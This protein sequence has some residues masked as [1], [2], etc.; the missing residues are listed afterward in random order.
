[1]PLSQGA[2]HHI[3]DLACTAMRTVAQALERRSVQIQPSHQ[4][5]QPAIR[6]TWVSP[7]D[8]RNALDMKALQQELL[9]ME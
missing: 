6:A 2:T 3:D 4:A 9:V 7:E 5:C 1:M 8:H